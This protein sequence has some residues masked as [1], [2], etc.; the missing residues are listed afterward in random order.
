MPPRTSI[1]TALL[2]DRRFHWLRYASLCVALLMFSVAEITFNYSHLLDEADAYNLILLIINSFACKMALLAVLILLLVPRFFSNNRYGLFSLLLIIVTVVFVVLQY[3][4]EGCLCSINGI[5]S[6]YLAPLY[7]VVL[8]V[9]VLNTQWFVVII[10]VLLGIY[11]KKMTHET[12]RQQQ[13]LAKQAQMEAALLKQQISPKLL[14]TTLHTCG[15]EAQNNAEATSDALLQ[16]SKVL[17]YQLYDS[18][19]EHSL[20]KSEIDFVHNYLKVL[21]FDGVCKSFTISVEGVV[22]GVMVPPLIFTLLMQYTQPVD[23]IE[24]SFSVGATNLKFTLVDGRVDVD[25]ENVQKQLS[26]LY[27]DDY[28]LT[29]SPEHICLTIPIN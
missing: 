20:L 6:R 26:L 12:Q 22:I 17:R 23:N 14:C 21:Q 24:C 27:S 10:S 19:R 11:L 2:L 25:F 9:M 8:D 13:Q 28:S 18:R 7:L 5:S 16:F 29:I 15:N 1:I 3:V 4:I